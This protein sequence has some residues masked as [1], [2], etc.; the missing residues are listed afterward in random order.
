MKQKG[1]KRIAIAKIE[2]I[3]SSHNKLNRYL[4]GEFYA[5]LGNIKGI[6]V[7]EKDMFDEALTRIGSSFSGLVYRS[8]SETEFFINHSAVKKFS[9]LTHTDAIFYWIIAEA[10]GEMRIKTYLVDIDKGK[11]F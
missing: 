11:I 1:W 9:N 4:L 8:S 7:V 5:R 6:T 3:D 10:S 2:S